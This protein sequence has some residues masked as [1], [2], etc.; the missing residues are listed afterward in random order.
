MK[1]LL[2]RV[3]GSILLAAAALAAL[4]YLSRQGFLPNLNPKHSETREVAVSVLQEVHDIFELHTVEYVYKSVFPYDYTETGFSWSVFTERMRRKS[5]ENKG[6]TDR[7]RRLMAI[8]NLASRA[9]IQLEK[10]EGK[11][12]VITTIVRAGYDL[13]DTVFRDP[14]DISEDRLEQFVRIEENDSNRLLYLRLPKAQVLEVRTEDST[15]FD[16]GYPD[17]E[18]P[19]DVWKDLAELASLTVREQVEQTGLLETAEKNGR[20]F[21]RRFLEDTGF[22]EVRFVE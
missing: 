14:A 6:L 17:I 1:R 2:R 22:S 19:P 3:V 4:F 21:I 5:L 13:T 9:G 7:E 16:Y 20:Q 8:H 10:E 15:S 12:V 18:I 11:F